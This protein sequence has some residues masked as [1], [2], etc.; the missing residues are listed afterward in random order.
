MATDEVYMDIPQVEIMAKNFNSFGEILDAAAKAMSALSSTL[1]AT[2]WLSLGATAAAA[3]YLD[4][5][6]PNVRKA[7]AKMKELSQDVVSAIR[8]YRDG[9]N[10][11]SR[12][13]IS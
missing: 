1:K 7:S 13:F 2:A 9:D 4:R 10:T 12:R 5:I 8:S 3:A 6:E 11:G